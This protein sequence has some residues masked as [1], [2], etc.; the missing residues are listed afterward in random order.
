MNKNNLL[1]IIARIIIWISIAFVATV[2]IVVC[3]AIAWLL[4]FNFGTSGKILIPFFSGLIF[5]MWLF[6]WAFK[7][8][9]HNKSH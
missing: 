2:A 3:G 7:R 8:I 1:N 4:I 9:Q 5:C 6:D